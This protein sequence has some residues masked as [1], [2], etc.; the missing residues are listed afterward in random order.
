MITRYRDGAATI[1]LTGDLEAW[2]RGAANQATSGFFDVAIPAAEEL[3]GVARAAWYREVERET[4]ESGKID[5]VATIDVG[6]SLASVSIGSL[7]TRKDKRGRPAVAFIHRPRALALAPVE[8][9]EGEYNRRKAA[10]GTEAD[11][12]FHARVNQPGSIVQKG[13]YYR[14]DKSAAASDG[15]LMIQVHIR[16]PTKALVTKIAP[17]MGRRIAA[18]LRGST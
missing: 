11:L 14:L 12:C 2:V 7:D 10:G 18:R 1:T 17:D 16:A 3:A 15:K 4:G 5:V 8:I 6:R 9:S 13:R